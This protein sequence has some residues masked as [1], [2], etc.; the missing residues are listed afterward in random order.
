MEASS[1]HFQPALLSLPLQDAPALYALGEHI[2]DALVVVNDVGKIIYVNPAAQT[3]FC[4]SP[5]N[6]LGKP[7]SVLVSGQADVTNK[8]N[9]NSCALKHAKGKHADGSVLMLDGTV[10]RIASANGPMY[11]YLL[12]DGLASKRAEDSSKL[13]ELVYRNT[14][15]GMLVIDSKGIILDVNP[16]F[17]RLRGYG[18]PEAIGRHI[19]M[20][21]SSRHD[22]EFY[23]AIWRAVMKAG[24]WQGEHIGQHKDGNIY[25]EWLSI[26]TIFNKDGSVFRRIMIFSNISEIKQ[27]EAII[28]N[29][30]NFDSLTELPNRQMFHD[31]LEQSIHKAHRN[32]TKLALMFL[33]LDRFKEVNDTL[34]HAM[35][36]TLLK[37][38]A[39]RLYNCV[40]QS[41]TVARLGGDEFTVLLNDVNMP[42]D[43][44][45][46]ARS[47][48]KKM[49]EP[50]V[51]GTETVF[52]ST[53]IG[54]TFYPED[55]T[56]TEALLN[57]ADQAMYVA[58]KRGRN[59]YSYF[60]PSMQEEAQIRM[61]LVNDLHV[62]LENNQLSLV[63]QP[64][65][66]LST[67]KIIKAEALMRWNHPVLGLVP[68]SQF[69]PL[70]EETGLITVLGHWAFC[71]AT[72]QL[73]QWRSLYKPALQVSVNASPVQF[74]NEGINLASWLSHLHGLGLSGDGVIIE[75]TEGM[76]LDA[77]CDIHK[78]LSAI[79]MAGMQ[80]SLD[81]FGTGYSSLSYLHKFSIDYLKIDQSFIR[82]LESAA[83]DLALCET[84]I[85]MGHKLGLK[86]IAEGVE[87]TRQQQILINAGCDFGQGY[88]FSHPV[89]ALEFEVYLQDR[90]RLN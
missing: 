84:V 67:G 87:T 3:L 90:I 31:R 16:A 7:L 14:S 65:I 68:P 23:T 48:L 75:I 83:D 45:R 73:Q 18:A 86:V 60:T 54:I 47:I 38:A 28:W 66:D 77:S 19:R 9:G 12:H 88:L 1:E 25:P 26:N 52:I 8:I 20:L 71:E 50:F 35:G 4:C 24:S 2:V 80:V 40:R 64:I 22:H 74:R 36:D 6:V 13:A 29:Q 78:Q 21:N 43:A 10:V 59:R 30:A 33:D 56:T 63:Y 5:N 32:K 37:Q 46:V 27:A 85:I 79:R 55:G 62:A 53:S 76:L 81:D 34:G 39:N 44:D 17:V 72:R 58:K 69:I 41:D 57:N 89:P 42:R 51:L 61:R 15:E 82:N 49:T 11:A 70:A